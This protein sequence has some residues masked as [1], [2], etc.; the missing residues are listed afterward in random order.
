[1][2][3]P[4]RDYLKI[5]T[6][7]KF[8]GRQGRGLGTLALASLLRQSQ[9]TA[10]EGLPPT[11]GVLGQGHFP[12]KAKRV[13]WL[14]MAGAPSQLD[15]YD[16]K[17][18]LQDWFDKDLPDSVRGGQRLTTMTASQARFPILPQ[19][20]Q[21]TLHPRLRLPHRPSTNQPHLSPM[22]T[23]ATEYKIWRI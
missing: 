10:S 14:F 15:T 7:R 13:I 12:A 19:R 22:L 3:T 11:P 2:E 9:A 20:P 21:P 18:G 1:M 4:I 17:P 5:Q 8:L 16:Y 23:S 6:R